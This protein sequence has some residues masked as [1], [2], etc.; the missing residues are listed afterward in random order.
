MKIKATLF[1]KSKTLPSNSGCYLMKNKTGEVI[2]VGKAK[3]LKSRVKTYFDNSTKYTK[4]LALVRNTEDFDFIIT[5]NEV[6]S[7]VLENNLIKK[8]SPKYNIRLR[9][10]KT[11]PY[12]QINTKEPFPRLEYTRRP[13]KKPGIQVYGPFPE[14]SHIKNIMRILTKLLGLRDCSLREFHSRKKPC[15]LYQ[16]HQCSAP[17]VSYISAEDYEVQLKKAIQF[18]QSLKGVKKLIKEFK[19]KMHEKSEN[20]EF[21]KAI[22]LRDSIEELDNYSDYY[23]KQEVE[24][25]KEG[26]DIDVIAHYYGLE[27]IDFSIYTIRNSLLIGIKNF[28]F[29]NSYES[30]EDFEED[31]PSI[32]MQYYSNQPLIP[33]TILCSF[34]K[35]SQD[36]IAQ[37]IEENFHK[38]VSIKNKISQLSQLLNNARE[39]AENSQ[40][41]RHENKNNIFKGLIDL[42]KLLQL[43]DI[44][45]TL[46]CYDVAIWQGSSP[47]AAQIVFF[48]GKPDKTKFRHY[49]LE[50]RPEKNND[51][52]M[53]QE[54]FSRRVR[55]GNLPDVFIV[56]GGTPQV[57][58]VLKILEELNISKPVIGIAK[59]KVLSQNAFHHSEVE[60]S[61]ER[62]VIPNRKNPYILT[63]SPEL[64]RIIVKMRDEAHRFSRRL[65]H[66]VEKKKLL[67]SDLLRIPGIGPKAVEKILSKIDTPIREL[68]KLSP[69]EIVQNFHLTLEQAENILNYLKNN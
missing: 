43:E 60:K 16:L 64:F 59:S 69:Q 17:C 52:A 7:L 34:K 15:L 9:D 55:S 40:R 67:H 31:I 1:E 18:F 23:S 46:E 65:H 44:P 25:N 37:A 8:Y 32:L 51:F 62:L 12:V 50:T 26:K 58:S 22:I 54:V 13:S 19:D 63:K 41:M 47:T 3:N 49:N 61:E 56:D 36:L 29:L 10:D 24:L 30:L 42:K 45:R 53:L 68:L 57:N 14:G 28:N 2:Y 5:T 20:E 39:H 38:K 6:E 33:S 35:Q 48:D 21:E 27:E 11:Y 4:T 66:K